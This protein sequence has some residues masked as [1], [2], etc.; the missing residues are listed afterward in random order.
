MAHIQTS[1]EMSHGTHTYE[2]PVTSH[3]QIG[4]QISH[5]TCTNELWIESRHA[6]KGGANQITKHIWMKVVTTHTGWR[7]LVGSPKLQIIFHKRATKYKSFLRKMTYKDKESYESS[8]PCIRCPAQKKRGGGGVEVLDSHLNVLKHDS[9]SS[10]TS[11]GWLRF[12]GSLE[13]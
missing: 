9:L 12:V 7:R 10:V 8:P 2:S 1:H 6:Y 5:G 4:H 11:V 13:L 3:I